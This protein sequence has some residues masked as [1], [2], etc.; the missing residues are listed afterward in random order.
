[1]LKSQQS[2]AR[3]YGPSSVLG[4]LSRKLGQKFRALNSILASSDTV[5]N[6]DEKYL[7]REHPSSIKTS[8]LKGSY[9][10]LKVFIFVKIFELYLVTTIRCRAILAVLAVAKVNETVS[11]MAK[12]NFYHPPLSVMYAEVKRLAFSFF[13]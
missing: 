9:L 11:C 2:C 13:A 7:I 10:H 6:G 12:V 3:I 4:L 5:A 1:M 8:T